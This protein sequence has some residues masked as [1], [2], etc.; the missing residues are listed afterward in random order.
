MVHILLELSGDCA[1]MHALLRWLCVAIPTDKPRAGPIHKPHRRALSMVGGFALSVVTFSFIDS[2][3]IGA[4]L[5]EPM[6]AIQRVRVKRFMVGQYSM[7]FHC[8][9]GD[10]S[11][12]SVL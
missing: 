9:W 2:G 7:D 6:R 11:M 8:F 10:D 12:V 4:L 1:C 3:G 5:C